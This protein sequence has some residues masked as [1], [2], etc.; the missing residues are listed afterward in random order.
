[1]EQSMVI[2]LTVSVSE[3]TKSSTVYTTRVSSTIDANNT[4]YI[5]VPDL[6]TDKEVDLA[7]LLGSAAEY[8]IID[9]PERISV[10]T[11]LN[12][13]DAQV[14]KLIVLSGTSVSKVFITNASGE[15]IDVKIIAGG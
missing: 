13:N 11:N 14:G 15:D 3:S 10:K 9:S 2:D 4:F 1:M 7:T 5:P 8:V 6:T 12:T